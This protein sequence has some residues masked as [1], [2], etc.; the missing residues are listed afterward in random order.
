M[1]VFSEAAARDMRKNL[2]EHSFQHFGLLQAQSYY[3]SF[4]N[5][6]ELL[7]QNPQ[8][9]MH[10]DE[11]R[12]GY[13]RFVHESHVLFYRIQEDGSIFLIRILHKSMDIQQHVD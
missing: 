3:E 1:S 13:R 2:L 9:G 11:L 8:M 6:L 4:Q 10:A 12:P 5:C 7:A